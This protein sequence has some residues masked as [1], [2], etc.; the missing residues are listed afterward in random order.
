[1]SALP[2]TPA[3]ANPFAIYLDALEA[4]LYPSGG[5]HGFAARAYVLLA[6]CAYGIVISVAYGAALL[7]RSRRRGKPL[8]VARK[9]DGYL[10]L[11]LAFFV[12][13]GG[14][15]CCAFMLAYTYLQYRLFTLPSHPSSS[16][17]P[18]NAF[19]PYCW[20]PLVLHGYSVAA[21]SAQACLVVSHRT[22]A[23]SKRRN[24]LLS[25]SMDW[26]RLAKPAVV[27]AIFWMGL[28][29]FLLVLLI[30]DI[31]F[32][33]SWSRTYSK[34]ASLES[35]L[36]Q[37]T[38]NPSAGV[39]QLVHLGELFEAMKA[40]AA[41]TCQHQ[42]AVVAAL[43]F[44]P[45]FLAL[46]TSL[47]TFLL[48]RL[49]RQQIRSRSVR[50][51]ISIH[52][53]SSIRDYGGPWSSSEK[54]DKLHPP[55]R[56]STSRRPSSLSFGTLPAIPTLA[57]LGSKAR[58][59]S[60]NTV[61]TLGLKTPL[62]ED[63]EADVGFQLAVAANHAAGRGDE[64]LDELKRAKRDLQICATVVLLLTLSLA[65]EN[66]WNVAYI[67]P[68]PYPDLSWASVEAAFFLP[69]WLYATIFSVGPTLL[70]ASTLATSA[71]SPFSP[72]TS[73]STPTPHELRSP[74]A[75]YL[76]RQIKI[77]RRT[78]VTTSEMVEVRQV[79]T[80]PHPLGKHSA[81]VDFLQAALF[82][83]YERP[84]ERTCLGDTAFP[85]QGLRSP[86]PTRRMRPS[87][88]LDPSA[89]PLRL[90]SILFLGFFLCST[91]ASAAAIPARR[92]AE[93]WQACRPRFSGLV[94]EIRKT[95]Q[96]DIAWTAVRSDG[97]SRGAQDK[98]AV[99]RK[100]PQKG[101]PPNRRLEWFVEP[102]HEDGLHSIS[103]ATYP[104]ACLDP[105][106]G[107]S[108]FAR[109]AQSPL[110]VGCPSA[111]PVRL[112]YSSRLSRVAY[113]GSPQRLQFRIV[114]STCD[115]HEDAAEGCLLQSA[116]TG[117]CVELKT[118]LARSK[119]VQLGWAECAW[120]AERSADW[121]RGD[122]GIQHRQQQLWDIS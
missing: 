62:A 83:R 44:A 53:P 49:L 67:V 22:S 64:T 101:E 35:Y 74:P 87:A 118:M 41:H 43:I 104:S 32:S 58:G 33:I 111:H 102:T 55:S 76:P 114:C 31:L 16:L 51:S 109:N 100:A 47:A 122:R 63:V 52:L 92:E 60:A 115:E 2:A 103:S 39:L 95:G 120:P 99:V 93:E 75:L 10:T 4:Q 57:R 77:W 108:S 69:P 27:N 21:A 48:C 7:W 8:W 98:I 66:C 119:S 30:P 105:A 45:V 36:V 5:A 15:V 117:L 68:T 1:M 12:P 107:S 40:A 86:R 24:S 56:P 28:L 110:A 54:A 96:R 46:I 34:I 73:L 82:E 80:A 65:A 116:S 79:P 84:S 38:S 70:L 94:Q 121:P 17:Y 81:A 71:A 19:R 11:N 9:V 85:A 59:L 97:S 20:I 18:T 6:V 88:S 26:S 112:L 91:L 23:F 25:S 72:T 89:S 3:G 78:E 37:Q 113:P 61:S 14:A 29:F 42:Q 90:L 50:R 13:A 106:S